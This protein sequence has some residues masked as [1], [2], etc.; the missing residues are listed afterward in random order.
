M[1]VCMTNACL[2]FRNGLHTQAY[3]QVYTI[4]FD[5]LDKPGQGHCSHTVLLLQLA[6]LV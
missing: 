4:Y 5:D 2:L 3:T 6:F 1:T